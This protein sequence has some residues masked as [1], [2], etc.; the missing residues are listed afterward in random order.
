MKRWILPVVG[1]LFSAVAAGSTELYREPYR[2]Q[3]HFTPRQGWVGD[4]DGCIRY[5][6]QY[7]LFWWGHAVSTDLV[8]WSE[9]PWPMRG[10][11]GSFMYYT[12]SAVVDLNNTSGLGSK[13]TPAMV[14][15][16]TAHEREG[17]WERQ[18]LSSSTNY[19]T[20]DYYQ[21]NPVLDR[22]RSR[23]FRDPDVFWYAPGGY[24]VMAVASPDAFKVLFYSSPDLKMW[25]Y[26]SSFGPVGARG[27]PW[28]CPVLSQLPVEGAASLRKWVLF[29]SVGPNAVQY[30]VGDF[31][32]T[33][34]T[35]DPAQAE[36][37]AGQQLANGVLWEGFEND[38]FGAWA[39]AGDAFANGPL[40]DP[41][42][43]TPGEAG[44]FGRGL[45]SS[46][47]GNDAA[48]GTLTSP[49]FRIVKPY[50]NFL[51][52]GGDHPGRTCVNLEVG[53]RVVR[54]A[55]GYNNH[56]L[57]WTGWDVSAW[58]GREARI[59]IV[60]RHQGGWGHVEVDHIMFADALHATGRE[61]AR[62]ADWGPDF[63]A[64]RVFRDY[65]VPGGADTDIWIAWMGNW[66]YA[67]ATPTPWGRGVHS[68]PRHIALD[69]TPQGYA[70]VQTPLAGLRA[71]RGP[72]VSLSPQVVEGTVAFRDFQPRR[73]T[74]E[75]AA[76]FKLDK[77]DQLFGLNLC[78]G[79]REKVIVAYDAAAANVILDRRVSGDVSFSD[80]FAGCYA[81][82]LV[83]RGDHVAFHIFVDQ[84]SIEV[85]V[86]EGR[87]VLTAQIF[88]KP[89]SLGVEVFSTRGEAT[90]RR[91]AAWELA[92]IW[93]D[94]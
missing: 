24:W 50:I 92:S 21:G 88:P 3:Y 12:G 46:F 34:F 68:I 90:L 67:N 91:L 59:V 94:F 29:C 52:G 42:P 40:R 6:G 26:L 25:T 1:L 75:L 87:A 74:Y 47:P 64:A 11:D 51:I 78:V 30:F 83:P 19:V 41:R 79:G 85:F 63:Y 15:I 49:P 93:S 37:L 36:Y 84:T 33:H 22:N 58:L 66:D 20:F 72:K 86:N 28:E 31:D 23:S 60:D 45:C 62:W 56:A 71:L 14:A 35:L 2:P 27:S 5:K 38:G 69:P 17:G 53:G 57:R 48:T 4:P 8:H 13:A 76:E 16:Y 10:D 54:A 18:C 80:R 70:L 39:V 7:H 82:P 65:D 32:G 77:P 81:A 73:N 55:T 43:G 89:D 44:Y 61:H 9:L